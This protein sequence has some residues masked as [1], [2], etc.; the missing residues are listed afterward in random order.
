MN[1]NWYSFYHKIRTLSIIA[2]TLCL[3]NVILDIYLGED[4]MFGT[5]PYDSVPY[6]IIAVIA[7][8]FSW[9]MVIKYESHRNIPEITS[10]KASRLYGTI[11]IVLIAIFLLAL[12]ILPHVLN[13]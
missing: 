12:A 6:L 4:N 2:L 1:I 8:A 9:T 11:A 3:L 10:K 5:S 7:T 13:N